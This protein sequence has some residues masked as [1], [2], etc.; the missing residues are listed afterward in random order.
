L[1][2]ISARYCRWGE[3]LFIHVAERHRDTA[4]CKTAIK[5]KTIQKN[6]LPALVACARTLAS[7]AASAP[8]NNRRV[9][10]R[11]SVIAAA[12]NAAFTRVRDMALDH[13]ASRLRKAL[14]MQICKTDSKSG[15]VSKNLRNLEK[16]GLSPKLLAA[17]LR[18]VR[19]RRF[20]ENSTHMIAKISQVLL[21]KRAYL[22]MTFRVKI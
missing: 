18:L 14:E 11:S 20:L 9:T 3:G 21:S 4:A 15:E 2:A 17:T 6:G 13:R 16:S 7:G 10:L 12:K 5:T 19:R 1:S 22:Q 8:G